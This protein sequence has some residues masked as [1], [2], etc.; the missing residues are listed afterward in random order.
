VQWEIRFGR[1]KVLKSAFSRRE[2]ISMW[3]SF[4]LKSEVAFLD[5]FLDDSGLIEQGFN[6]DIFLFVW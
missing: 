1:H 5:A 4:L 2:S 3:I 6:D